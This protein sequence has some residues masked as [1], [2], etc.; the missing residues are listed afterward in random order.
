MSELKKIELRIFWSCTQAGDSVCEQRNE[1][2]NKDEYEIQKQITMKK[3]VI[4]LSVLLLIV[5]GCKQNMKKQTNLSNN[6]IFNDKEENYQNKKILSNFDVE[7]EF[8]ITDFTIISENANFSKYHFIDSIIPDKYYYYWECV[9]HDILDINNRRII[10]VYN[11]DSLH[12]AEKTKKI[13]SDSGFFVECHPGICFHYIIAIDNSKN[14]VVINSDENFKKFIGKIDN[15]SEV[16]L[17]AR[18]NELYISNKE[19]IGGAYK[20]KDDCYFLYL[21][22]WEFCP[23]RAFS[24]RAILYKTGEFVIIDKKMYEE[25]LERCSG[26]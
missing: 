12:F 26:S 4:I 10:Y 24:V 17:I 3:I 1:K 16:L 8:N 14:I 23:Y 7:K 25:D 2:E 13:T 21:T 18:L 9:S 11:G 5:G 20:E 15:L 6:E 19:K 22:E